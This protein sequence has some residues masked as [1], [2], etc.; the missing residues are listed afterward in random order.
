M[1]GRMVYNV[2]LTI[3]LGKAHVGNKGKGGNKW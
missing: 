3:F 1:L 2:Q